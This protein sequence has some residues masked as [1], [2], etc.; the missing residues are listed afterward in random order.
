[1][2]HPS[3]SGAALQQVSC[4]AYCTAFL[5]KVLSDWFLMPFSGSGSDLDE[6]EADEAL[7]D[8]MLRAGKKRRTAPAATS[9]GKMGP[10]EDRFMKFS[11][12]EAFLED[13]EK[14]AADGAGSDAGE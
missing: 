13:A 10:G 12:M 2:D 1:M 6:D 14:R 5:H 8:D 3:K 4:S 11:E 7:L 9:G